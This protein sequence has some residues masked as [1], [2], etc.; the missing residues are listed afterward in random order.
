MY[1]YDPTPDKE[2]P[3]EEVL[4]LAGYYPQFAGTR[5]VRVLVR[6]GD[7]RSYCTTVRKQSDEPSA[8]HFLVVPPQLTESRNPSQ[9][10]SG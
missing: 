4:T 6:T 10:Y 5:C 3:K 8:F 2:Q 9:A 7:S 1:G